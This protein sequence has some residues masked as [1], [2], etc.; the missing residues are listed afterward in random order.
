M[1]T[2]LAAIGLPG[3]GA[4]ARGEY[5]LSVPSMLQTSTSDCLRN[6][7]NYSDCRSESA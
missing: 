5:L 3:N 6:I 4:L 2:I 7:I 1:G